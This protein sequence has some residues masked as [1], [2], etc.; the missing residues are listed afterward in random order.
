[1]RKILALV[2]ITLSVLS[3]CTSSTV[4]SWDPG[5]RPTIEFNDREY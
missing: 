1:M 3:A 2:I 4:R 5:S